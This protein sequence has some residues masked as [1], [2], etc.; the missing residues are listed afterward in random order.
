MAHPLDDHPEAGRTTLRDR[1]QQ[2]GVDRGQLRQ[3]ISE[4]LDV[5]VN[6]IAGFE[7]YDAVVS[8]FESFGP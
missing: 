7:C 1:A 8:A 6:Q 4:N 3:A 5:D 2:A